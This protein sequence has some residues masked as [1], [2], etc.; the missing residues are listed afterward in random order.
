M[1]HAP[2]STSSEL[3]TLGLA[4][5]LPEHEPSLSLFVWLLS[6]SDANRVENSLSGET[7][8]TY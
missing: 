7:I 8:I 5:Q 6:K 3:G 4:E 1:R 2:A